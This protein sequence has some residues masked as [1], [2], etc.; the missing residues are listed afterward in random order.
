MPWNGNSQGISNLWMSGYYY[1]TGSPTPRYGGTDINFISGYADTT[2]IARQ[3]NFSDCHANICDDAGNLLFYSNGVYI[4]NANNDTMVNGSGL[5]PSQYTTQNLS[6]GL[7][8]RQGNLILPYPN[9][10]VK[11]YLIHQTLFYDQNASDYKSAEVYYSLIDMSLDGGLGA[12]IQKN[13]VLNADTLNPGAITACKHANGRDWWLVFHKSA[14][15]RYYKYLLTP[16]G[17]QGPFVQNIGYSIPVQNDFI[18]QSCFSP[19]GEKFASVM[20]G[21]SMNVMNFDR[22]TGLFSNVVE[23]SINDSALGRGVAF[24][25]NS[26]LM[27]VSSMKYM[28]QFNVYAGNID[29][30]KIIIGRYDGFADPI[31][32]FYTGFYLSQI[33]YDNKIYTNT[34]NGTQWL[35]VIH[36]PDLVGTDCNFLQ[37]GLMLPTYNGLTIP[38][39]PN[40]FLGALIGSSCDSLS[41]SLNDL[42]GKENQKKLPAVFPKNVKEIDV[43][44]YEATRQ[45]KRLPFTYK[46]FIETIF[47]PGYDYNKNVKLTEE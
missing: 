6:Y 45:V 31:P 1:G 40:Y 35:M 12:V 27:Y 38:N 28:Y 42:S 26:N 41:S 36:N 29:S 13:V 11:Y 5:N 37:H 9:D 25:P 43:C 22:C 24:S 32:P 44:D 4:A 7:R 19:N 17:F 39:F 15:R 34:G 2:S 18:W 20:A 46:Q 47:L 30:T 33:G 8:I 3:M 14:G 10:S 16:S 21:D 23:I